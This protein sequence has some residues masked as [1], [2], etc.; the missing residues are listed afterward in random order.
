[1]SANL[2]NESSRRCRYLIHILTITAI[3]AAANVACAQGNRKLDTIDLTKGRMFMFALAGQDHDKYGDC[4]ENRWS[5]LNTQV[6]YNCKG[7]GAGSRCNID[8]SCSD[9]A[10]NRDKFLSC[11]KARDQMMKECYKGGDPN[12]ELASDDA[13]AAANRC[14]EVFKN[15]EHKPRCE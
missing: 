13:Y 2:T 8:M 1:M 4:T 15:P 11:G 5:Q 12:H 3:L 7:G 10:S 14:I 6:S 9:L